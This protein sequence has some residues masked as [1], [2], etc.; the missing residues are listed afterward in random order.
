MQFEFMAAERSRPRVSVVILR[1]DGAEVLMV[2][3]CRR[4]GSTY[5]QLPRG[6]LH[7]GESAEAGALR[8]LLEETGLQGRVV[9][10]LFSIPYRLGSSSTFLVEVEEDAEAQLGFDPEEEERGYRKLIAVAWRSLSDVQESP[11][12]QI[13]GI[14]M[15]YVDKLA[16][17][18]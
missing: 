12:V 18:G 16:A 6:G 10:W 17:A 11:E 9:R 2:Q 14:V 5:W 15:A 7:D 1:N 3:H 8:E 13:L 4:D